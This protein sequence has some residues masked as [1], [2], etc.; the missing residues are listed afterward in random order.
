MEL[1]PSTHGETDGIVWDRPLRPAPLPPLPRAANDAAEPSQVWMVT[2]RQLRYW[3]TEL[4]ATA[5]EIRAAV[6]RTGTRCAATLREYFARSRT[7]S[8]A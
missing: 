6:D 8:S 4:G 5:Y 2:E 3:T 1:N 7:G